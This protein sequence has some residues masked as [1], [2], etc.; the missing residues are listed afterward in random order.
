MKLNGI[1]KYFKTNENGEIVDFKQFNSN[2][3]TPLMFALEKK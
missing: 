3:L 1:E 2:F